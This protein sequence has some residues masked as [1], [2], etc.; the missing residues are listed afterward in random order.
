MKYYFNGDDPNSYYTIFKY[1]NRVNL[2][3]GFTNY[4]ETQKLGQLIDCKQFFMSEHQS[5]LAICISENFLSII[6]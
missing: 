1:R 4:G 6:Q 3:L 5:E 2:K